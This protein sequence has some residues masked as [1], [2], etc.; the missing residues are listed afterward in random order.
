VSGIH[1]EG[2]CQG[3]YVFEGCRTVFLFRDI[4]WRVSIGT[5]QQVRT[6]QQVSIV[7]SETS[8]E[9][10]VTAVAEQHTWMSCR[11]YEPDMDM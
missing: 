5:V 8:L 9:D 10:M 1:Q 11:W 6:L 2:I 3:A 4:T 7:Q